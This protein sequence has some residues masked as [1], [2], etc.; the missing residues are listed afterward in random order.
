MSPF[1]NQFL[2]LSSRRLAKQLVLSL[3]LGS[4]RR[5]E[6]GKA[7]GLLAFKKL[8]SMRGRDSTRLR[9]PRRRR[10][11]AGSDQ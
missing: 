6:R 11:E 10:M 1:F 9:S 3:I 7:A 8:A 4:I 5:G 2:Y